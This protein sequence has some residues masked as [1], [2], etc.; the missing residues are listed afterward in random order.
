MMPI[1]GKS[2]KDKPKASRDES[3]VAGA[4]FFF[5][6][7]TKLCSRPCPH[8]QGRI[9]HAASRLTPEA[10]AYRLCLHLVRTADVL[11]RRCQRSL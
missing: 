10:A 8:M 11:C 2:G 9:G 4:A 1:I 5:Q 7:S 3:S 6:L